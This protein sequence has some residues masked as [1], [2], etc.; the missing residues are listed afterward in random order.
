M[1][2]N[3]MYNAG[4]PPMQGREML[5]TATFGGNTGQQGVFDPEDPDVR[6]EAIQ[7]LRA[8]HDQYGP[9]LQHGYTGETGFAPNDA[10]SYY[11]WQNAVT[12]GDNIMRSLGGREPLDIRA[13]RS[14]ASQ[15]Q[16]KLDA[17]RGEHMN[18]NR[19]LAQQ[20]GQS[21]ALQSLEDLITGKS[22]E[23]GNG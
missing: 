20:R 6:S 13:G 12:E 4:I 9:M 21:A 2:F 1:A 15:S 11:K 19:A 14:V 23:Y 8:L 16:D 17:A 18:R 3:H 7:R 10:D 5:N 22:L